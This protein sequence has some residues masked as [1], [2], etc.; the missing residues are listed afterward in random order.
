MKKNDS[1]LRKL[2][3][4]L[5]NS[6]SN[7]KEDMETLLSKINQIDS[8]IN[9]LQAKG[10]DKQIDEQKEMIINHQ[11]DIEYLK[12]KL[13]EIKGT[14]ITKDTYKKQTDSIKKLITRQNNIIKE[15]QKTIKYLTRQ[16]KDQ[17]KKENK[18]E[19]KE[20]KA[21]ERLKA[22]KERIRIGQ[23]RFKTNKKGGPKGEFVE[24]LGKGDL[25]G[26]TLNDSKKKHVFK[27]PKGFML[28]G[29]ARVYSGKG[30]NTKSRLYFNKKQMVWNDDK[31]TAFLRDKKGRTVSKVRVT[32][33][34]HVERLK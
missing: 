26:Y 6:F 30:K 18:R 15:Q 17:E 34:R 14:G 20:K 12:N 28:N 13:S 27:F 22:K 2:D 23:V 16:V 11:E 24:I 10:F 3:S 25:T 33:G 29:K 1:H 7:V 8:E 32:E 4:M 31:D 5:S 9:T 19:E 21:A